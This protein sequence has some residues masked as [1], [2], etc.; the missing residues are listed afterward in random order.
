M[1]DSELT[2]WV[3]VYPVLRLAQSSVVVLNVLSCKFQIR[4]LPR[5]GS[6][7]FVNLLFL[8]D[9][10]AHWLEKTRIILLLRRK[11]SRIF[12]DFFPLTV[13]LLYGVDSSL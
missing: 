13:L 8:F 10:D 3:F 2:D 12:L 1:G 9:R 4:T 7:T 11:L 6:M 5:L